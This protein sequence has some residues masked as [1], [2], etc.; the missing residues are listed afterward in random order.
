MF[1]FSMVFA[2]FDFRRFCQS[3]LLTLIF[4]RLPYALLTCILFRFCGVHA[5]LSTSRHAAMPRQSAMP[6]RRDD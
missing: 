5:D 2:L 4:C 1:A 3:L 6:A